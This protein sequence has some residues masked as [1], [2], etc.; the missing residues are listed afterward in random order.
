MPGSVIN[1]PARPHNSTRV[2][3]RGC[4]LILKSSVVFL[5]PISGWRR[6]I[7]KLGGFPAGAL[8]ADANNLDHTES[9]EDGSWTPASTLAHAHARGMVRRPST[10][11]RSRTSGGERSHRV[12]SK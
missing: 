4:R 8:I 9:F 10:A 2:Q 11:T 7:P 1:A 12:R 5:C 6:E 3:R